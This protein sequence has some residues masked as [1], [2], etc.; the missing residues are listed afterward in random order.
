MLFRSVNDVGERIAQS[1]VSYF[2]NSQ[3]Q[4]TVSRLKSYGLQMVLREELLLMRSDKLKGQTFVISGTFTYHS[5]DEYKSMIERYGG[6]NS[7]SVSGKT[8]Y[9]LSGENMGPTKLA[10]AEKLGVNIL[11][12]DD[13][14][15][16]VEE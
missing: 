12:E 3:N 13:F 15:K 6:K 2:A 7:S 10:K 1:V 5:R 14:L 9:V 16:L 4:E 11:N 8:D